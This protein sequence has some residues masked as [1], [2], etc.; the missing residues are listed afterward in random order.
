MNIVDHI[1]YH[2]PTITIIFTIVNLLDQK[3]YLVSFTAFYFVEYYVVGMMKM[4]LKEPRPTGY[5]DKQYYDGGNYE[6]IALYG[7]PSGH[8][9]AVWYAVTFLWLVKQSYYLLILQLALCINTM[10]QRWAFRKHTG[11]QLFVG[12]LVGGSIGWIAVL[13][14]KQAVK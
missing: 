12:A 13:I 2:G 3:K 10:Y 8:S 6:G 7:M 14:T 4:L 1:G 11:A 9:S 5:A